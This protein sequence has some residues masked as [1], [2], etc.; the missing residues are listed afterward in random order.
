M[1]VN[2]IQITTH[3]EQRV[4]AHSMDLM[5]NQLPD[6]NAFEF[7][8]LGQRLLC[9]FPN[10]MRCAVKSSKDVQFV[11]DVKQR[12]VR[13]FVE[14]VGCFSEGMR[15]EIEL[16]DFAFLVEQEQVLLRLVEDGG[17]VCRFEIF[18]VFDPLTPSTGDAVVFVQAPAA[19]RV[20]ND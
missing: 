4:A 6:R 13:A 7:E 12:R 19:R 3:N 18:G 10:E 17:V 14:A 15:I 20:W 2:L 11:A 9:L 16:D 5:K 8:D 1:R